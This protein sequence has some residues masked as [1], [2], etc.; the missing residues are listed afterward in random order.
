MQKFILKDKWIYP[1]W[2]YLLVVIFLSV[3]ASRTLVS[4]SIQNA[5]CSMACSPQSRRSTNMACLHDLRIYQFCLQ[6]E[7]VS[8][9]ILFA[10]PCS[11]PERER[12]SEFA[13]VYKI[14]CNSLGSWRFRDFI[15][16]FMLRIV[17][18]GSKTADAHKMWARS[19]I[20]VI[21]LSSRALP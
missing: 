14:P 9:A 13:T 5:T 1:G 2:T 10:D 8:Q 3:V 11:S 17:R 20:V 12:R 4:G 7:C 16:K 15:V 6:C 19:G 18:E 21:L